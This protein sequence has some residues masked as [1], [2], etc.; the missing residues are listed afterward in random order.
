MTATLTTPDH[1]PPQ[2][3]A[4]VQEAGLPPVQVKSLLSAYAPSFAAAEAAIAKASAI[5][6]TDATQVKAMK[7]AHA[8]RM[9]LREIRVDADKLRK[10]LKEESHRTTKAI[11]GAFNVLKFLIEP[12]EERLEQA[13][14]FAERE[15]ARRIQA[16]AA[17]RGEEVRP[18]GVN[19]EQ[20]GLGEMSEA[21]YASFLANAKLA[22]EARVEAARQAEEAKAAA[23]RAAAEEKARLEAE[24]AR[25]RAEAETQQRAAAEERRQREIAE[26]DAR[27]LR[28][29]A[30][31]E[32]A[33][34]AHRRQ[35]EALAPDKLKVKRYAIALSRV[36]PPVFTG[37][38]A[39]DFHTDVTKAVA[40]L[41]KELEQLAS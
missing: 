2:L 17:A 20:C 28:E 41:I 19:A 8:A 12:V 21:A 22:H 16:L 24:N 6:V 23:A 18:Y 14:K 1:N 34:L 32:A 26:A 13:E 30:E 7:A 3:D 38:N 33:E 15:E 10:R 4:L 35:A 27:K 25:L 40:R 31:R 11:D 36:D 5:E 29:V 9:E 37:P 39:A